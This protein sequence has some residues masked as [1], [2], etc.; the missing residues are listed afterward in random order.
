MPSN[1]SYQDVKKKIKAVANNSTH[2]ADTKSELLG[3]RVRGW[4][5]YHKHCGTNITYGIRAIARSKNLLS[6]PV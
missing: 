2:G 3:P 5:N 6:N 1:D 4:R